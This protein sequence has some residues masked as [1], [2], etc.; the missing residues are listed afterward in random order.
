MQCP[1]CKILLHKLTI[2]E[3]SADY[4]SLCGGIWFSSRNDF[5][6]AAEKCANKSNSLFQ[7]Y[8]NGLI[9]TE[10]KK[11]DSTCFV[12]NCPQCYT[13]METINY[14]A[15]SGI[16]INRCHSC[17]G[18]WIDDEEFKKIAGYLT[19]NPMM[20]KMASELA[21]EV[22]KIESAKQFSLE[23]GKIANVN[24]SSIRDL[25]TNPLT[26]TV[27]GI[28]LWHRNLQSIPLISISLIFFYITL[29]IFQTL[30]VS[31]IEKFFLFFGFIPVTPISVGLLTSI[32]IHANWFHLLGN[33]L[34]LWIFGPPI[35]EKLGRINFI[36]YYFLCGLCGNLG[37]LIMNYGSQK[38][39]IGASG[40]ISGMIGTCLVL[41]PLGTIM[42][43]RDE[44]PVWL[45]AV[46]FFLIQFGYSFLLFLTKTSTQIG[47]DAHVGGFIGGIIIAL[48][49]K[50][51][52]DN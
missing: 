20:D 36:L 26:A 9:N 42:T 29:F 16:F 31:D 25:Y 24:F 6:A 2:E 43:T 46:A 35:E 41:E 39:A 40:A 23:V 11:I 21:H 5:A 19:D 33:M 49:L 13:P 8:T 51:R 15:N 52:P 45:Y 17:K 4:C 3:I 10:I 1:F 22:R 12:L 47:Y 38:P 27:F 7:I 18:I 30:A 50:N 34:F 32:F 37:Y 14:A 28:P 48:I 44:A